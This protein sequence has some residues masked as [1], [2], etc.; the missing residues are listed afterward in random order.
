MQCLVQA[1]SL[2]RVEKGY[3]R[4]S[5]N[6]FDSALDFH[7]FSC[8]KA[9]GFFHDEIEIP[10]RVT[11]LVIRL[12]GCLHTSRIIADSVKDSVESAIS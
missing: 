3:S 6:M 7:C 8:A 12:S 9:Q 10:E 1:N 4:H 2:T 5:L 11:I